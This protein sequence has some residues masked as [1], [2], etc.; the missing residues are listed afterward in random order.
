MPGMPQIDVR[1]PRPTKLSD[2]GD[3][4][5]PDMLRDILATPDEE[6]GFAEYRNLLGP[7]LPA[8][9][10]DETIYFLPRALAFVADHEEDAFEITDSVVGYCYEN[11]ARLLQ[12]GLLDAARGALGWLLR[13]WSREFSV[14]HYDRAACRE[15]EWGLERF[16]LVK[17]S[18]LVRAWLE[19]LVLFEPN[20][21]VAVEYVRELGRSRATP[22]QAAWFL[23]LVRARGD[24]YGPWDHPTIQA[25]L[26]DPDAQAAAARTVRQAGMVEQAPTY[27]RDVF[28]SLGLSAVGYFRPYTPHRVS[29]SGGRGGVGS[30]S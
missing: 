22:L 19:E 11:A 2:P 27:W 16:D 5:T 18:D 17:R 4:F 8:G 23:E 1:R 24:V 13:Y 21:D 9:T 6:M 20:A 26:A 10:Y 3:D 29:G 15:K 30:T 14:Q 7:W 25:M 12:D 28:D